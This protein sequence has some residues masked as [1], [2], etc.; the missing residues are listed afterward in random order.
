MQPNR[1]RRKKA[2]RCWSW[3]NHP[4]RATSEPQTITIS[5]RTK[6]FI[7]QQMR[8]KRAGNW[9][10]NE[11]TYDIVWIVRVEPRNSSLFLR[12]LCDAARRTLLETGEVCFSPDAMDEGWV[13]RS[14]CCGYIGYACTPRES[15]ASR[16][17]GV[18]KLSR[19]KQNYNR[20]RFET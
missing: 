15:V 4:G 10:S 9:A 19:Y 17:S 16:V 8:S 5:L 2:T 12:W 7:L 18:E 6:L 11:P 20:M 14:R 1:Q 13:M 3:P